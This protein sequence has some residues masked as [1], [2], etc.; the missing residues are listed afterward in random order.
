MGDTGTPKATG[1]ASAL[2]N[3]VLALRLRFLGHKKRSKVLKVLP[4]AIG[5]L[6][7]LVCVG[8]AEAADVKLFWTWPM[9]EARGGSD[10]LSCFEHPESLRVETLSR[11]DLF[12]Y[13]IPGRD[14]TFAGSIPGA[15]KN[16]RRD[17]VTIAVQDSVC[18]FVAYMYHYDQAGNKSCRSNEWL[19]AVPK[20]EKQ[21]GLR[22]TYFDDRL[23]TTFFTARIEPSID[24]DWNLGAPLPGMGAETFSIRFEGFLR[25]ST[26]GNYT[27]EMTVEDGFRAWI[28]NHF[29]DD[30]GIYDEHV[31]V[32]TV[33]LP[34]L[35]DVPF[36]LDYT[37]NNGTAAAQLRWIPPGASKA[38][39][40]ASAFWH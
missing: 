13:T 35:T 29:I 1:S 4:K 30:F 17:S 10:T 28:G 9:Y 34:V 15:G 16:G 39:I 19:G 2:S 7:A 25:I 18:Y 3:L 8:E 5:L 14:T 31:K 11:A 24:F 21:P 33:S 12:L 32:W 22:A 20:V 36:R 40:P 37:A 38:I 6:W 26:G 27:F 23:L